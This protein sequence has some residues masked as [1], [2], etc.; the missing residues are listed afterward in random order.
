MS[1]AKLKSLVI[2]VIIL[3]SLIPVYL[4]MKRLRQSMRPKESM[5]RLFLYL[6]LGFLL[7]FAYTFL[8]V[9]L[10]KKIFPDS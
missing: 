1:G 6:L 4:T 8:V 9:L 3:V 2:L 7:V 10:I 5:G